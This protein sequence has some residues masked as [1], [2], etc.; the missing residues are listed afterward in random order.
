MVQ[1]AGVSKKRTCFVTLIGIGVVF[2]SWEM[3][4][5]KVKK[6]NATN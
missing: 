1:V 4:Y 6:D 5:L 2:F 3:Y